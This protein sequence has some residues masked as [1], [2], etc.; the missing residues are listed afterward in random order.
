MRLIKPRFKIILSLFIMVLIC[1]SSALSDAQNRPRLSIIRDTE[2]ETILRNWGTPVFEAARLNPEAIRIILVQSDDV[3]AFVAG[4][5]NIFFYTGLLEKTKNSGEV[6]GVLAHETGH[7][8]GGHLIRTREAFERASYESLLSALLGIGAAIAAG[9]G[10]AA[11][12]VTL[13]GNSVAQRRFLAHSRVQ[14]S[15]ADQAAITFL[16]TAKI[17]P[18]GLATFMD[19]LKG[20]AFV[21]E[22]QQSEYV[23]TH[24]LVDNRVEALM[25]RIDSSPYK[26]VSYPPLWE[27]QHARMVAKLIGFTKPRQIPWIYDD[28]DVSIPAEYARAIAAY[29]GNRVDEALRR[30]AALVAQ[31][32]DNPY[33]W[34]LQGQMLVDFGQIDAAIPSYRKAVEMLPNSPLIETALAHALIEKNDDGYLSE[35]V[36]ALERALHVEPRSTR[37]HRL[38]AT[39]FGRMNQPNAA[40]YHLAEEAVLQRRF[41]YARAHATALI[42]DEK[43]GS[44]LW[45]K[46]KDLLTFIETVD[47]K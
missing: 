35:A 36:D 10:G 18:T 23:R 38:L 19:T 12:A 45:I 33:F 6:I 24:P 2:I 9:D 26:D 13:G 28:S 32:P 29:R 43:E 16:D 37:I 44:A 27:E 22:T 47:K 21:P 14:E 42:K 17:N 7:I 5:S 41:E 20:E 4:G 3:N 8:S 46:A 11:S 15:S 34:E 39:A 40:K 1:G 30:M 25:R 31:E